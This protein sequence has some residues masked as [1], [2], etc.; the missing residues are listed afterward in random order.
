MDI[1]PALVN[2]Q[3]G[4]ACAKAWFEPTV[5]DDI[6]DTEFLSDDDGNWLGTWLSPDD[7]A[8]KLIM[9]ADLGFN[10]VLEGLDL[11][12]TNNGPCYSTDDASVQSFGAAWGKPAPLPPQTNN[13]AQSGN[14]QQ[15]E[16]SATPPVEDGAAAL[17]MSSGGVE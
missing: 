2:C 17:D 13:S 7:N 5:L 10:V 4:M 1:L 3:L 8:N 14:D 15:C 6:N 9:E 16:G 11:M 12:T